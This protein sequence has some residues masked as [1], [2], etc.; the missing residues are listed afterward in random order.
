MSHLTWIAWDRPLG[1]D[2]YTS[3]A[4]RV[5]LQECWHDRIVLYVTAVHSHRY[6]SAS[7]LSLYSLVT[8]FSP[9]NFSFRVYVRVAIGVLAATR[10]TGVEWAGATSSIAPSPRLARA[11]TREVTKVILSS[12][13]AGLRD[14][15]VRFFCRPSVI[16]IGLFR[17]SCIGI[18]V[19]YLCSLL[20]PSI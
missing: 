10:S 1:D 6:S 3:R 11:E 5:D 8:I 20:N 2:N 15:K 14:A 7:P 13:H 19:L 12:H 18:N 17:S 16:L 9:H 4:L